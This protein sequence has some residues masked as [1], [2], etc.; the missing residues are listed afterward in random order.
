MEIGQEMKSTTKTIGIVMIIT[1]FSRL[2]SLASS[3][4]YTT[5]YGINLEMDIYSYAIQLPNI[6]FTSLGNALV[7]I[8]IPIFAGYI[9]TGHK[10]RAFRFADN[11]ITISSL[12]T[13]ALS[14]V[15]MAVSPAILMLTRFRNQGYDFALTSLRIMF[16]VMIFYALSFIFQGMLQSLGRYNMPAIISI[17]S[18]VVIILYV[19]LFGDNYGVK[20]LLIATFLGLM[21]QALILVPSIIKT[22]YRYRPSFEFRNKDVTDALKLT[23]AVIISASAYQLNMLFNTTLSANFK[24][25]VSI[26][27]IVQNLILYA[28]LAFVY[29]V[30]AVVFP[31][32]TMMAARNDMTGFKDNLLK[33]VNFT[34]Y[35]LVPASAG[36]IA[37][38]KQLFDLLYG[39][40]KVTAEDVSLA[41]SLLT[42]YAVGVTGIGIKEVLDR[43]FYSLKDTKRPAINGVVMM[44]VN[45]I[46]CLGLIKLADILGFTKVLGIPAGYSLSTITGAFVLVHML[47]KKIGNFGGK[48]LAN[49]LYKIITASI[50]ML[51]TVIPLGSIINSYLAGNTVLIKGL[52]LLIPSFAGALVYFMATYW[53]KVDQ[54]IDG[55]NKLK[56]WIS[57]TS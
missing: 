26:M 32:L 22:G 30:T 10:E 4:V 56:N 17:P 43:A 1:V 15:G 46:A 16:P 57:R 12:F 40:G 35:F 27:T 24:D 33:V 3:M 36:F 51:I 54:A 13:L 21:L 38:S 6:I 44:I 28:V 37:V 52:R 41:G 42:I 50:I 55:F 39:W 34:L 5:Y 25:T 53:M 48:V 7:Y 8:V 23:P 29:S 47:K 9:G 45:V 19:F 31:K 14:L 20:G 49:S 2:L 11:V 18:S